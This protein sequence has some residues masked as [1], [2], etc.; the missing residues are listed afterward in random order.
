[1]VIDPVVDSEDART[2]MS[3][4]VLFWTALRPKTPKSGSQEKCF[5]VFT[6]KT[7]NRIHSLSI[8]CAT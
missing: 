2:C 1:M 4:V 8:V 5:C 3:M 7:E 6:E